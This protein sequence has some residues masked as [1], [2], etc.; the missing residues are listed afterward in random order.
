M[1]KITTDFVGNETAATTKT[2]ITEILEGWAYGPGSYTTWGNARSDMNALLSG[3]AIGTIGA[4]EIAGSFLPKINALNDPTLF[5]VDTLFANDE[6]GA[7]SGNPFEAFTDTA[8]T[9]PA[10]WGN[11]VARIDDQSPNGRNAVQASAALRPLLGRAPVGVLRNLARNTDNLVANSRIE[12][13][14]SAETAAGRA[15]APDLTKIVPTTANAAHLLH[16]RGPDSVEIV[17]G[18]GLTYRIRVDFRA[19]GYS[20]GRI[21]LRR[22]SGTQTRITY[23][24]D[25]GTISTVEAGANRPIIVSNTLTEIAPGLWSVELV[26]TPD[27]S[28]GNDDSVFLSSA[29]LSAGTNRDYAG[30]GASG[31][32]AG[33]LQIETGAEFTSYQR[34]GASSIDVTEAGVVSQPFIRFDLSDDVLPTVFPDGGTFD[35]AVFGRKGSWIQRDVVRTAGQSINIGPNTIT[36]GLFGLLAALGDIVG[37]AAVDRTIDPD[38]LNRLVQYYRG[39]GAKGLLVPGPELIENGSVSENID[40]WQ[41]TGSGDV[42]WDNGWLAVT[43]VVSAGDRAYQSVATSQGG[44]YLVSFEADG[45]GENVR[46]TQTDVFASPPFMLQGPDNPAIFISTTDTS[47]ISFGRTSPGTVRYRNISV[48]ALRPQEDW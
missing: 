8:G 1:G 45:E 47:F 2:R 14:A 37:W 40:G 25:A 7:F 5:M 15:G 29:P 16:T 18:S 26:V 3:T 42:E 22:S 27:T 20:Q 32:F 34:V 38:E 24:L 21:I 43:R 48:R 31:V 10:T 12:I 39:R 33:R 13:V 4:T 35:V 28:V 36:G 19:G 9:T 17:G 6:D 11:S 30:D 41:E 44:A 23:N 46:V